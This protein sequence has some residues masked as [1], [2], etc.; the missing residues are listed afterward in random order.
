MVGAGGFRRHQQEDEIDGEAVERLE[1]DRPFK[2]RKDAADT[3]AAGQLAVRDRDA[4]AYSGGSEVLALQ[5]G[6]ENFTRRQ[7]RDLSRA[8]GK[9]LQRLLLAI[10][11]QCRDHRILRQDFVE[12]HFQKLN[13]R[14]DL[15]VAKR[16]KAPYVPDRTQTL[17]RR[18][19]RLQPP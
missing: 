5:N 17:R 16:R 11:A 1:I 4:V 9:L 12:G 15:S 10:H 2:P 8:F 7:A 3:L 6:V 19:T 14:S 13:T 18:S